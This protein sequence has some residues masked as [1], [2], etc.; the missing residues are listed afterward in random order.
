M[1]GTR[2]TA[3]F[4]WA[5]AAIA[6]PPPATAS[7]SSASSKPAAGANAGPSIFLVT[8]VFAALSGLFKTAP[9]NALLPN[10]ELVLD[11]VLNYKTSLQVCLL[12]CDDVAWCGVMSCMFS[13]TFELV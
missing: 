11:T 4:Q 1:H 5:K 3:F 13:L 12:L 8:G 7:G 6:P 10:I 2:L 9:R